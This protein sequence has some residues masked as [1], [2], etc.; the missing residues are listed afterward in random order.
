MCNYVV[1]INC[2]DLDEHFS[3]LV[4]LS[5]RNGSL[6]TRKTGFLTAGVNC[7]FDFNRR[8]NALGFEGEVERLDYIEVTTYMSRRKGK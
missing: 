8:S 4:I 1:G 7:E 5:S 6:A 2:R 3:S